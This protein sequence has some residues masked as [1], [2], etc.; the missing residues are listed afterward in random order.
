LSGRVDQ[1]AECYDIHFSHP[2]LVSHLYPSLSISFS[3]VHT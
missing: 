3:N 1:I 2:L